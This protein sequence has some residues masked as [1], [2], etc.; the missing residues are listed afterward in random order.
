MNTNL[1]NEKFKDELIGANP[2]VHSVVILTAE[3]PI[4]HRLSPTANNAKMTKLRTYL[5]GK[6]KNEHIVFRDMIGKFGNI[7]HSFMISNITLD[8]AK[9]IAAKYKQVSFIYGKK[10]N[11]K[12]M[13]GYY[14]IDLDE[15]INIPESQRKD[16][17][18]IFDIDDNKEYTIWS[19][20]GLYRLKDIH[21]TISYVQP[22]DLTKKINDK[23]DEDDYYSRFKNFK[24]TIPFS[25]FSDTFNELSKEQSDFYNKVFQSES[26]IQEFIK[27]SL[28]ENRSG[29][30]RYLLRG[31]CGRTKIWKAFN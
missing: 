2:H 10:L 1:V 8:E 23:S 7:E 20:L 29:K 30:S 13:F 31:T 26:E 18:I 21:D 22:N 17:E 24:F 12:M 25:Y 28:V 27:Q 16:K 4:A 9:Q 6:A 5:N 19:T 3:N 11:D 14:S 15:Y